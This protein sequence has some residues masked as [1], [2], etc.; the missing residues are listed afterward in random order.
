MSYF[1]YK[2]H[3]IKI[4]DLHMT[5]FKR[6]LVIRSTRTPFIVLQL[7]LVNVNSQFLFEQSSISI[8]DSY[9]IFYAF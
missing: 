1:L 7:Q 3:K 8:V 5:E 6:V 2:D 9:D 4:I